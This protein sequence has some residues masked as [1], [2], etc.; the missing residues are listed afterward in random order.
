MSL[1]TH[2]VTMLHTTDGC[3]VLMEYG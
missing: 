2:K 1:S 3:C